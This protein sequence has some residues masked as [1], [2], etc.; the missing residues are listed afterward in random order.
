MGFD[1]F[2]G[3]RVDP[4]LLVGPPQGFLLTGRAWLVDG[5]CAAVT[6]GS[7]P[8]DNSVNPVTVAL[9]IG[10]ALDDDDAE[11]F[12]QGRAVGVGVKRLGMPGRGECRGLAEA[13]VH[14]N[15]VERVDATG[16]HHVGLAGRQFEGGQVEGAQGTAA[17]RVDDTVGAAEIEMLA[18]P[19]G[20]HVA[21]Q[22]G[23]GIFLPGHIGVADPLHD[24]LGNGVGDTGVFQGLAPAG[25][26]Q[27]GTERHDQL[28]GAGD[29]ENHADPLTVE[30]LLRGVSGILKG[31]VDSNQAKQ[32]RGI[33]RLQRIGQHPVFHR[34]EINRGQES[35]VLGVNLVGSLGVRIE[36]IIGTP[37]ALGDFGDRVDPLLDVGP[38]SPF[39]LCPGK[40]AAYT[41]NGQRHR[42]RN[43]QVVF[44]TVVLQLRNSLICSISRGTARAASSSR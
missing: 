2:Y 6:G 16:H 25:M 7:D 15:V 29:A 3:V 30:V 5:P 11:P 1:Q 20:D 19:P 40:Q 28:Q 14:E 26:A 23:E 42:S 32:L 34:V 41:D 43:L 33:D 36:I 9:C 24:V 35:A 13:G 44:S 31:L 21:E 38:E 8:L 18:D 39:I 4:T 37:V 22:A 17:G 10:Q 12:T 27:A